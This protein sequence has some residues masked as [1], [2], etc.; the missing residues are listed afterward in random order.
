M[1]RRALS[2]AGTEQRTTLAI[3][4]FGRSGSRSISNSISAWVRILARSSSV[5]PLGALASAASV[6]SARRQ[7]RQWESPPLRSQPAGGPRRSCPGIHRLT[8]PQRAQRDS[9]VVPRRREG[10]LTERCV[11]VSAMDDICT[12]CVLVKIRG[13][14]TALTGARRNELGLGAEGLRP[15]HMK[16]SNRARSRREWL[17][18]AR[19]YTVGAALVR[20]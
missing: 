19:S 12:P 2:T 20:T 4:P 5:E 14:R 10:F 7:D 15:G 9:V 8:T 16:V 17:D 6:A 13:P 18:Q 11:P 3:S 1:R